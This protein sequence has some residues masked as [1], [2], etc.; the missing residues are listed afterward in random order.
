MKIFVKKI[1]I[2]FLI[3]LTPVLI[4][5]FGYIYYDPF[6]VLKSYSDYSYPFVVPNRDYISTEN[7]YNNN[8]KYNYNSFIFGS[9]R[10]LGF[11]PNSW[12]EY[13][14]DG[15]STFMFDASGETV[16]G[17]YTKLKF[18][19]SIH[20]N[21]D[22]VL[23]VLCRD[24]SFNNSLNLNGHLFI[25]DPRTTGES[26]FYFQLA[27]F[28]AYLSTHFL[29]SF[30]SY[31]FSK[32]FE[33][34]MAGYIENRKIT[35]DTI[36]N[37]INILDQEE[38]ISKKANDYYRKRMEVFYKRPLIECTD[39]LQ[40]IDNH[41]SLMLS[42]I[43]NIL[44]KNSTNYKVVL[45]PLYEQIKFNEADFAILKKIFGKHLY[46]F[47]GKNFFTDSI[48]NYYEASHFRPFVGDSIFKLIYRRDINVK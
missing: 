48:S 8:N 10:T 47:S 34:F 21:I 6:K 22:N 32:H 15:A 30:Y 28:K 44:E 9:S 26:K 39:S 3:G 38:E 23:I 5:S 37:E 27:F 43:K 29:Y 19:D 25:K 4:L 14:P 1:L 11:R 31:T 16:Y 40:R 13:L 20:N 7:F 2:F 12:A 41:Y 24:V 17:I 35:Y 18:L 42:G 36:T 33:P 46:D 45:S